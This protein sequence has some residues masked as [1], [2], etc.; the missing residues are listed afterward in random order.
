M[1][2][3]PRLHAFSPPAQLL[4]SAPGEALPLWRLRQAPIRGR[5]HLA[6]QL[7]ENVLR[8]AEENKGTKGLGRVPLNERVPRIRGEPANGEASS[9]SAP[10]AQ[11]RTSIVVFRCQLWRRGNP[12]GSMFPFCWLTHAMLTREMKRTWGGLS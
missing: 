12:R 4:T 8:R 11:T 1:V 6:A 5:D 9:L 3:A 2:T 7:G 10:C